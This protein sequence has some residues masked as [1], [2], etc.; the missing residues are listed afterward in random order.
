[1]L[2]A[3]V[4]GVAGIVLTFPLANAFRESV[5]MLFPVFLI[6]DTTMALQ[7]AAALMVGVVAAALPAWRASRVRI[8]DGLRAIV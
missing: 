8:V 2:I 4:G 7:M 6:S 5:A 1:M 3:F